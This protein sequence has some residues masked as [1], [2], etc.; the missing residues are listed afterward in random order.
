MSFVKSKTRSEGQHESNTHASL[1]EADARGIRVAALL[2]TC[3]LVN[4][5]EGIQVKHLRR[6]N[7]ELQAAGPDPDFEAAISENCAAI[8]RKEAMI[9]DLKKQLE[10]IEGAMPDAGSRGAADQ[11]QVEENGGVFL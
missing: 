5:L 7:E 1:H 2:L 8:A 6:S 4:R 3:G 11:M 10:Q 9:E